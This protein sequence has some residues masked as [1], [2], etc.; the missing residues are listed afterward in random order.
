MTPT[1]YPATLVH[2]C[3]ECGEPPPGSG[4]KLFRFFRPGGKW[5]C[6]RCYRGQHR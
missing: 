5:V 6:D 4:K 2:A 3:T 1:K